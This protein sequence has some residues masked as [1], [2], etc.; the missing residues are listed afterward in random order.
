MCTKSHVHVHGERGKLEL[1]I[2]VESH[3][4]A[5]SSHTGQPISECLARTTNYHKVQQCLVFK[6]FLYESELNRMKKKHK[7][8]CK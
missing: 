6:Y 1:P 3:I 5:K 2:P 7:N 4:H 8:Y